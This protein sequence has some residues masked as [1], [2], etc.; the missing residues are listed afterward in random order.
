MKVVVLLLLCIV[1][2]RSE[3][4]SSNS[5]ELLSLYSNNNLYSNDVDDV[6]ELYDYATDMNF[7]L[8]DEGLFDGIKNK[9]KEYKEKSIK[10]VA[11]NGNRIAGVLDKVGTVAGKVGKVAGYVQ[12]A[13]SAASLIPGVNLIAAPIAAASNAVFLASKAVKVSAKAAKHGVKIATEYSKGYT[14]SGGDTKEANRRA[15]E[16]LKK[17]GK[18]ALRFAGSEALSI[19]AVVGG[20]ALLRNAGKLKTLNKYVP[21]SVKSKL[22]KGSSSIGKFFKGAGKKISASKFGQ[23][24]KSIGSKA[25]TKLQKLDDKGNLL[26]DKLLKKASSKFS[27]VKKSYQ[28]VVSKAKNA[29]KSVKTKIGQKVYGKGYAAKV[30]KKKAAKSARSRLLAAKKQVK[31]AKRDKFAATKTGQNLGTLKTYAKKPFGSY[32]VAKNFK[33]Q[34]AKS[35]GAS[36]DLKSV[37]KGISGIG[38]KIVEKHSKGVVKDAVKSSMDNGAS[39]HFVNHALDIK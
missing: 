19:A 16:Q 7:L 35:K 23:S 28:S 4:F 10:W 14:E 37:S 32:K 6:L 9:F 22:G 17:S 31:Q 21:D 1:Y 33:G 26:Q 24:A 30:A 5:Y 3:A 38:K 36:L 25:A 34:Y 27:P 39:G 13:A 29:G 18:A 8:N 12:L 20:G 11:N 15:K 2:A